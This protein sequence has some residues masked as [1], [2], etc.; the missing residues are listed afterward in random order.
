MTASLPLDLQALFALQQQAFAAQS[1]PPEAVRRDRLD[2]LQRLVE[3]HEQQIADAISADFGNRSHHET[4]IAEVF[5][6]LGALA[7]TRRH[8]R[9]WMKK[10]RV[11]TSFHSLPGSSSILPQPLGVAGIVSPWNYPLQLALVPA[12]AALAAGNRVML[13]PSELT[14]R[15]SQLLADLVAQRFSVDEFTVVTG[16]ADV[17]RAFV[18]LPFDHL[19]FTGSTAVGRQVALA[20]AANLTPVT[21]ELG[22]KSPAIVDDSA[23]LLD[24]R[25][26]AGGRQAVQRRPDLHRAGLRARARR[27]GCRISRRPTRRPSRRCTRRSRAMPTTPAS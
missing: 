5:I 1:F 13:K 8:L 15:F 24:S 6:V 3:E 16:D 12:I 7:H 21:L 9:R 23:D 22:G 26:Q 14:P 10:R 27:R 20:A 25:A 4:A 18:Q 17:G 19:F 11:R 2:R